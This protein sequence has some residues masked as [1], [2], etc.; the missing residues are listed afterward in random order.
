M[1]GARLS[2]SRP[3][4]AS[5][6]LRNPAHVLWMLSSA[7]HDRTTVSQQR[8]V[9]YGWAPCQSVCGIRARTWLSCESRN[10]RRPRLRS[11]RFPSSARR[12]WSSR[13]LRMCATGVR[14]R[15]SVKA[16][17]RVLRLTPQCSANRPAAIPSPT[18]SKMNRS[19]DFR[20]KGSSGRLGPP[21]CHRPMTPEGS[22][23]RLARVEGND[24]SL[25][26]PRPCRRAPQVRSSGRTREI[27]GGR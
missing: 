24:D 17:S 10:A 26:A 5:L 22:D 7:G 13:R 2:S 16:F 18:C 23:S 27:R 19:A 8:R 3:G 12:A 21:A 15:K 4:G 20:K 25:P 11:H 9:S 6:T 14:P 1:V